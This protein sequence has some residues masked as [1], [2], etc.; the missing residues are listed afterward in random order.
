[1]RVPNGTT[2]EMGSLRVAVTQAEP[3]WLDLQA[4]VKKTCYLI[5]VAAANK[6]QLV[7]FPELWI[8]GYP[9][10]IWSVFMEI[11]D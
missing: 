4:A 1:M 10:W 2:T 6:A 5:S 9:A 3:C 11:H 8:P 7:T